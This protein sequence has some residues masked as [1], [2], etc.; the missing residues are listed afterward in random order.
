MAAQGAALPPLTAGQGV[1]MP[2]K[3]IF[4]NGGQLVTDV[5]ITVEYEI[6]QV[7]YWIGF[8]TEDARNALV[9]KA[10]GSY[11]D[12]KVLTEK[13]ISTMAK[14]FSGRTGVTSRMYFGKRRIK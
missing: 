11:D 7:L 5:N 13:Y 12:V 1:P 10:F 14:S 6:K 2:Q 9:D 4:L 8:R 3:Y